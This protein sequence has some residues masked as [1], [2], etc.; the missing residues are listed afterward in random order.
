MD[1]QKFYE[2][3]RRL[4]YNPSELSHYSPIGWKKLF[5]FDDR[6]VTV[7]KKLAQLISGS[8]SGRVK[9]LDIAIGDGVYER[10]LP[11]ELLSKCDVYAID[12]SQTQLKR[13]KD[14]I[15]EGKI[16][17]LNSEKLP[18]KDDTF[19]I[20]I[21]SEL[22]EHVFYPDKVLTE[23]IRVLK[24]DGSFLL[25]YPNSGAI[26]LRLSLFFTGASP[27]LNYPGNKE[28]IRY[29]RKK[30]IQE[31]IGKAKIVEYRGL[32]SLLFAK[33]NFPMRFPVF[34]IK[35][36]FWNRFFPNMALGNVMIIKK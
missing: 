3:E 23:A 16:V 15:K 24:K 17:D 6:F 27:L 5:A 28:H 32:G 30:D 25:T 1:T 7:S 13:V 26:Q 34:R 33:W 8:K 20:V 29:F 21:V 18:F 31:M 11:E 4:S 35:Q 36:T 14:I 22:L 2:E 19:D 9:L 10:M 12:I